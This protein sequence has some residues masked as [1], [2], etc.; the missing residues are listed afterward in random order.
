MSRPITR[1]FHRVNWL[2]PKVQILITIQVHRSIRYGLTKNVSFHTRAKLLRISQVKSRI[3]LL[4]QN[5]FI[6]IYTNETHRSLIIKLLFNSQIHCVH[7]HKIQ[8]EM[9]TRTE[10]C[11]KIFNSFTGCWLWRHQKFMVQLMWSLFLSLFLFLSHTKSTRVNWKT[12]HTYYFQLIKCS[13]LADVCVCVSNVCRISS[14]SHSCG[15]SVNRKKINK[16]SSITQ[17][18]PQH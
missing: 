2:S 11:E 18:H 8:Q 6:V 4:L 7:K 14:M 9:N 12:I 13:W 17:W 1:A 15:S 10:I 5:H 3:K 16:H